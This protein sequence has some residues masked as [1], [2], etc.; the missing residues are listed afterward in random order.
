MTE[1]V[2]PMQIKNPNRDLR[3]DFLLGVALFVVMIDHIKE[4]SATRLHRPWMPISTCFFDSA[5]AFV[6]LSGMVFG[7]T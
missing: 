5:E 3:L 6:F 2:S 1:A 4:Q 7:K